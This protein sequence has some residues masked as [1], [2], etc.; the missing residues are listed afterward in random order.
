MRQSLIKKLALFLLAPLL[1]VL[2][3]GNAMCFLFRNAVLAEFAHAQVPEG[4]TRMVAGFLNSAFVGLL[5]LDVLAV[6]GCLGMLLLLYRRMAVPLL[7]LSEAMPEPKTRHLELARELPAD[8]WEETNHIAREFNQFQDRLRQTVAIIRKAGVRTAYLSAQALQHIR[9]TM[10][11]SG[12]QAEIAT[13]VYNS[14]QSIMRT[15]DETAQSAV[16]I[17]DATSRELQTARQ[18]YKQLAQAA[19]KVASAGERLQGFEKL[20]EELSSRSR[21]I[22]QILTLIQDI[23][24]QTSLLAL[25]AGIE[26]ARVGE[27]GRGFA[28][29]AGEVRK[30]AKRTSDAAGEIGENVRG[31]VDKVRETACE[32]A[33]ISQANQLIQVAVEAAAHDFQGMIGEFEKTHANLEQMS[34]AFEEVSSTNQQI[35]SGVTEI[36]DLSIDVAGRM[37][38]NMNT[39]GKLN[40]QTEEVLGLL[41]LFHTGSGGFEQILN[42]STYYRDRIQQ[43]MESIAARGVDVFDRRYQPVTG[44]N[45]QKYEVAYAKHFDRELQA[46]MD[47]ARREI[48]AIYFLVMDTNG[49]VATHHAASS[50]PPT[51][52]AAVDNLHSRQRRFY[53]STEVERKRA[54]NT[55][56]YL[57]QTYTRNTGEVLDDVTLPVMVQG[58]RYGSLC[59]GVPPRLLLDGEDPEATAT[60]PPLE[61]APLATPLLQ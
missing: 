6:A 15:I 7:R 35:H 41:S 60:A 4:P 22:D 39:S 54:A 2:C 57:L 10:Q 49:F 3:G 5:V 32:T 36:R 14:S 34:R 58:R 30:V 53:N 50:Q 28:I 40:L 25:N 13:M 27:I 44:T 8:G 51:G 59:V 42:L 1:F 19:E 48:G 45:P 24:D 33:H 37:K 43:V 18:S 55:A 11:S 56:P 47:E 21:C 38:D 23:A 52:D 9:Q 16:Q 17:A 29:V 61:E 26:A 46:L 12:R 31:I 20:V